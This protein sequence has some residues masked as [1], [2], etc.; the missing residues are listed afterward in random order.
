MKNYLNI[1]NFNNLTI[2]NWICIEKRLLNPIFSKNE[3]SK[4]Y[5]PFKTEFKGI[6]FFLKEK[7]GDDLIKNKII[8]ISTKKTNVGEPILVLPPG[9]DKWWIS[10]DDINSYLKFDFKKFNISL[11]G[12][13]LK[14][15]NANFQNF[16]RNN[17]KSWKIEGSNDDINYILIHEEQNNNDFVN[18]KYFIYLECSKSEY[19]RYIKISQIDNHWDSIPKHNFFLLSGIEF[20]GELKGK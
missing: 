12:Y 16:K 4:I 6:L 7:F 2:Q 18:N 1:I 15:S 9:T 19:Y 13:S 17:P 20:F 10:S 8:E 14:S 3:I 5:F 11:I